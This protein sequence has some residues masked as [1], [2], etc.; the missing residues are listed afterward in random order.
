MT[1]DEAR[2]V[3]EAAAHADGGCS[4]CTEQVMSVLAHY[5][6]E[7]RWFDGNADV[8]AREPWVSE[9]RDVAVWERPQ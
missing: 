9:A 6:P 3:A 5:F 8:E 4:H 1:I 2:K 7:F